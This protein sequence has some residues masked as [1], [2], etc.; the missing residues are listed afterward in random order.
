MR[1]LS[2]P[3]ATPE[4]ASRI[5]NPSIMLPSVT[6]FTG[7]RY[8]GAETKPFA[9]ASIT[10]SG[11]VAEPLSNIL[12]IGGKERRKRRWHDMIMSD[13]MIQSGRQN[14]KQGL[15]QRLPAPVN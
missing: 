1:C 4:V 12:S 7:G 5:L 9:A 6:R 11:R 13:W 10:G 15:W 3:A 8:H 2:D 14:L